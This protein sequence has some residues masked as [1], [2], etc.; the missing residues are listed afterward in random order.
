MQGQVFVLP[1][2]LLPPSDE[3]EAVKASPEADGS[4]AYL[5]FE[6]RTS[7]ANSPKDDDPEFEDK[8]TA[9]FDDFTAGAATIARKPEPSKAAPLPLV[10]PPA[11][12]SAPAPPKSHPRPIAAANDVKAP[13]PSNPTS[14]VEVTLASSSWPP[15]DLAAAL[16]N[17]L[18][19]P[20]A[21]ESVHVAVPTATPAM[22]API[23]PPVLGPPVLAPPHANIVVVPTPSVSSLQ[24]PSLQSTMPTIQISPPRLP[25]YRIALMVW[26]T[27][28]IAGA[29][30]FIL[31]QRW[32]SSSETHAQAAA[33]AVIVVPQPT[34]TTTTAATPSPIVPA[35]AQPAAAPP[36]PASSA[37]HDGKKKGV[38]AHHAGGSSSSVR[39]L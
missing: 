12:P 14:L 30:F 26:G 36:A 2:R 37:T 20:P 34:T 23:A 17:P 25:I 35:Q 32:Q 19:K 16:K 5:A 33:P 24:G 38:K 11:E 6:D 9:K 4:D 22:G 13:E 7:K 8:T 21:V 3:V 15:A 29:I 18:P 28:L 1:A 39:E 10:P 31:E 27:L